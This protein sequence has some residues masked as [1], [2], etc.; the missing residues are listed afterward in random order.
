MKKDHLELIVNNPDEKEKDNRYKDGSIAW[1]IIILGLGLILF[2]QV[3]LPL[4]YFLFELLSFYLT[5][6]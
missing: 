2:S 4:G 6:N 5:N 3:I 1:I